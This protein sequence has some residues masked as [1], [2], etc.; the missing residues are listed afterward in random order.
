MDN[1]FAGNV[2]CNSYNN[3]GLSLI[4]LAFLFDSFGWKPFLVEPFMSWICSQWMFIFAYR[5][6]TI[7]H[8]S[9][10]SSI[11]YTGFFRKE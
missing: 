6:N 7:G 3:N 8:V 5:T 2:F 9:C 1:L 4:Y 11:G 10:C